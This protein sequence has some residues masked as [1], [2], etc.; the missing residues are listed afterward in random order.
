[1]VVQFEKSPKG[2]SFR[3]AGFSREGYA[4]SQLAAS[5][6]LADKAGFGMTRRVFLR[7][8]HYSRHSATPRPLSFLAS[9]ATILRH[10]G[11]NSNVQA[12]FDRFDLRFGLQCLW[13]R[14]KAQEES[15]SIG[16][17]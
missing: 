6:F 15:G 4:V 14:K 13:L 11:R 7:Q 9:Y 3:S 1:V 5:R 8:L 16:R 2:L 12:R 10:M 17:S